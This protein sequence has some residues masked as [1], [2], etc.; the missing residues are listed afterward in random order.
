MPCHERKPPRHDPS[1]SHPECSIKDNLKTTLNML[2]CKS[3]QFETKSSLGT[4]WIGICSKHVK[5]IQINIIGNQP[6]IENQSNW[7]KLKTK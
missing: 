4:S 3:N 1:E 6:F 2:H 7:D 5:Q